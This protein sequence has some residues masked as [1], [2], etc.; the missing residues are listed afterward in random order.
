MFALQISHFK[1]PRALDFFLGNSRNLRQLFEISAGLGKSKQEISNF[2][3]HS[4][5]IWGVKLRKIEINLERKH[6]IVFKCSICTKVFQKRLFKSSN[7][8]RWKNN[9]F[10]SSIFIFIKNLWILKSS[11]GLCKIW[12]QN[13]NAHL[14]LTV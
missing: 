13:P 9:D 7:V 14:A 8:W 11:F 12:F 5:I 1:I 4:R 10:S 6:S 2:P 3:S